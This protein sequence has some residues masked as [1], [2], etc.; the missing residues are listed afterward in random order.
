M[1]HSVKCAGYCIY[2]IIS[3]FLFLGSQG[4]FFIINSKNTFEIFTLKALIQ[5]CS[6]LHLLYLAC[7]EFLEINA[8]PVSPESTFNS[9][10]SVFG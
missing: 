8:W 3:L 2:E 7:Y 1:G 6:F 9:P 4:G 10:Q 5:S